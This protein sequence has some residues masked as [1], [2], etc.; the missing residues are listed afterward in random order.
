MMT[1]NTIM[2]LSKNGDGIEPDKKEAFRY[3]GCR[4]DCCDEVLEKLYEKYKEEYKKAASYKAVIRKVDIALKDGNIVDFGFCKIQNENLYKNMSGCESAYVFAATAG[5]GA[6]R[7]I[8]RYNKISPAEAMIC[9][10][11]ASSAIEVWCDEINDKVNELYKT[12]PRFS[13]GYGGVSL[14]YQKDV[15]SFLDAERKIGITL[16]DALM[17]QPVKSVTAFIGIC[18]N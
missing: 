8:M 9:D 5:I 6:D 13:P 15:L 4:C 1:D 10:C 16:N 11:I 14:E 17:M 3:M 18:E 12:K 7:L 2:F